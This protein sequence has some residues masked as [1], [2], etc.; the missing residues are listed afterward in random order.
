[1]RIPVCKLRFYI[2][3]PAEIDL[4]EHTAIINALITSVK[5]LVFDFNSEI[6]FWLAQF[7]QQGFDTIFMDMIDML[8]IE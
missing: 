8:S 3:I 1:M 4:L 5:T 2:I 6:S 7:A